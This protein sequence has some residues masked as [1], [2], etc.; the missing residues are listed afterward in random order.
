MRVGEWDLHELAANHSTFG[1]VK[2]VAVVAGWPAGRLMLPY[3]VCGAVVFAAAFFGRLWR[4]PRANQL[5][6]V[7]AFMVM[8]PPV[9]YFYT[10][11]HLYAPWVVL[12]FCAVRA[13]QRSVRVR[14]WDG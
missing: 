5:L 2:M 13:E 1:W 8:L 11:V 7:T 9:S 12:V 4:M 3:Y 14:G 6:G 10:L